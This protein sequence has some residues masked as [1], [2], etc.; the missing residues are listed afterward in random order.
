[1]PGKLTFIEGAERARTY[2]L[3]VDERSDV[4][5]SDLI[6]D[7]AEH[8]ESELREL[9]PGE[10]GLEL[11]GLRD[12]KVLEPGVLEAI[13]GVHP[14]LNDALLDSPRGLDSDPADYPVFVD[15]GTGVFGDRGKVIRMMPGHFMVINFPDGKVFTKTVQGQP[16]Q[17]FSERAYENTIRWTPR[18]LATMRLHSGAT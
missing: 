12:S 1:M 7:I 3:E 14:D 13:A 4:M 8:A 9:A 6:D 2:L 15:Q 16:A 5:V 11:V 18:R 17:K 10:I